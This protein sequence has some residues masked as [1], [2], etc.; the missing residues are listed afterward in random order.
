MA[1]PPGTVCGNCQTALVVESIR[2]LLKQW[3]SS[4]R[5]AEVG[6]TVYLPH[7]FSDE[8]SGWLR[9]ELAS[10]DEFQVVAGWSNVEGYSFDPSDY[11]EVARRMSDFNP[12]EDFP[13][14][15]IS[16]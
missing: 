16:R 13:P 5:S 6:E 14:L 4:I 2:Q 10:G 8:C 12:L 3:A 7:D 15:R 9:C 1:L 11:G